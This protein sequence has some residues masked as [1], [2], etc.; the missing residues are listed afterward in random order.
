MI[1]YDN[2]K[3][4]ELLIAYYFCEKSKKELTVHEV[5]DMW[6]N[7]FKND[8]R[9]NGKPVFCVVD[10]KLIYRSSAKMDDEKILRQYNHTLQNIYKW[11]YNKVEIKSHNKLFFKQELDNERRRGFA[12]I[13]S[14][15]KPMGLYVTLGE[16]DLYKNKLGF[17]QIIKNNNVI[18][19]GDCDKIIKYLQNLKVQKGIEK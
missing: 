5:F 16:K 1:K 19:A 7:W 6:A 15:A 4:K 8:F 3:E 13:L 12:K 18:T 9:I 10:D 11:I 2:L 14:F 17:Y